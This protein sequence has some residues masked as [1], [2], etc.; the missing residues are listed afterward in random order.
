MKKLAHRMIEGPDPIDVHVGQQLRYMRVSRRMSQERLGAAVNLT[1]QQIQK[2]EKGVNR[3]SASML[4]RF[5]EVFSVTVDAFFS[6]LEGGR[7]VPQQ[8]G[9]PSIKSLL[10]TAAELHRIEE[11]ELRAALSHLVRVLARTGPSGGS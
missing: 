4:Y 6:G 7:A 2:Y 11:P 8:G 5:A 10:A 3:V 1:F 9:V